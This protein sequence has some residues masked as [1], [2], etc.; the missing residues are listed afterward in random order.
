MRWL[1][2]GYSI[3]TRT[4]NAGSKSYGSSANRNI[5]N[6]NLDTL[7]GRPR[8]A[9][10]TLDWNVYNDT[11]IGSRRQAEKAGVG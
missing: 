10:E 9:L 11:Q 3:V 2:I 4:V 5:G 8:D 6:E 1:E 7:D